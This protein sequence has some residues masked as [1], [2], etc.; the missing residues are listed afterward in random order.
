MFNP[1]RHNSRWK[2]TTWHHKS[3]CVARERSSDEY[4]HKRTSYGRSRLDGGRSQ[5]T[6]IDDG[7][8]LVDPV[9][10]VV[11]DHRHP[12]EQQHT[13][14]S[15]YTTT[16]D[17]QTYRLIYIS[18]HRPICSRL[19]HPHVS[20]GEIGQCDDVQIRRRLNIDQFELF[21]IRRTVWSS[22]IRDSIR[23]KKRFAG[24]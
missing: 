18:K 23:T 12:D 20:H 11:N 19:P 21:N 16:T 10:I 4:K 3:S 6:L 15:H 7:R 14:S 5:F 2:P 13:P 8:T 22:L 17:L 24:P 1:V 9:R